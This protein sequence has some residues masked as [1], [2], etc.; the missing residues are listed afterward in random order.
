MLHMIIFQKK[1]LNCKQSVFDPV[2]STKAS[3]ADSPKETRNL[4][5]PELPV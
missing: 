5:C 4:S 2:S 1:Q 3:Y